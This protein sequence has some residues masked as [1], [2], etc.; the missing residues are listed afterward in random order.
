MERQ[1]TTWYF[2]FWRRI[3]KIMCLRCVASWKGGRRP[4]SPHFLYGTPYKWSPNRLPAP[5]FT[6]PTSWLFRGQTSRV[7]LLSRPRSIFLD[8]RAI[9]GNEK[10]ARFLACLKKEKKNPLQFVLSDSSHFILIILKSFYLLTEVI[11]FIDWSHFIYWRESFY[12]LTGVILFIES[13]NL[14]IN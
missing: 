3:K 8:Q 13:N 10:W 2:D 5:S 11:L 14:F 7:F 9:F 4:F 12:L 6:R 1:I